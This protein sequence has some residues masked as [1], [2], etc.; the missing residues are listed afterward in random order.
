VNISIRTITLC[1]LI[2]TSYVKTTQGEI[3]D[4]AYRDGVGVGPIKVNWHTALAYQYDNGAK[5]NY[6]IQ[7][8]GS[9][10]TI[11]TWNSF[12]GGNTYK[13]R[14]CP[15]GMS[16]ALRQ[17]AIYYATE[18]IG[19][20][21]WNVGANWTTFLEDPFGATDDSTWVAP[22]SSYQS[23]DGSFRCD[24][25]VE[26]V[27]AQLGLNACNIYQLYND[28]G[29]VGITYGFDFQFCGPEYQFGVY[30]SAVQTPPTSVAMTFPFSTDYQNPTTVSSSSVT[31]GATASDVQSGLSYNQPYD[32]WVSTWTGS[33]W[34]TWSRIGS[35]GPSLSYTVAPGVNYAFYV[36]AFDNDGNGQNSGVY[37]LYTNPSVSAPTVQ[38]GQPTGVT[39]SSATLNGTITSTGGASIINARFEYTSSTFPGTVIYNVPVSGNTFSYYLI[40][41]QP[42]TSY[43]YHCFAENSAGLWNTT[44][45]NVTFTT[46]PPPQYTITASSG[47][48]G[49][50]SP[51]GSLVENAGNNLTLTAYPNSNFAVNQWLVDGYIVQ[52]GGISYTLSN[53]QSSHSVQVTY[54]YILPQYTIMV[55]SGTGGTISPSGSLIEN[56]GNN[57]TL[58][59]YPNS[60]YVV[61]QWLVDGNVMQSEG[62]SYTL[63]NIQTAHNVLVTFTYVPPQYTITASSGIGGAISPSGSLVENAG[64]NQA[65]TAFPNANYVVNQ[66]LVDGNVV[67][68]GDISYTLFNI[69][70]SHS[71]QV[72]FTYVPPDTTPPTVTINNPTNGQVLAT[73]S[74][75]VSGTANDPGNPSSGLASVSI[76][77]GASNE[78][79][80]ANWQF[81][82]N[83]NPGQN[84]LIV[85]ATDQAGNIGEEQ[86]NVTLAPY[87]IAWGDDTFGQTNLPSNL[88]NVVAIAGG[89]YH[90]LALNADGTVVSWG[91]DTY[92]ETNVPEG[93]T[94]A[95]AIAGGAYYSLALNADGTVVSWGDDTYGQTNL[96]SNLTNVVAIAGC[97]QHSLA[98][99]SNGTVVGWGS[100]IYGETDVP[101]D[102]TNVVGIAGGFWHSLALE[103]NGTVT[104]WG[105]NYLGDGNVP[106]GLTNVVSIAAG[107]YH[108]LA[109]RSDGT[110]VAWGAGET[111]NP[112]DG[113]DFGQSIVPPGLTNVVA[114]AAGEFHSLAL[115]SDG[116]VIAWGAGE[117]NN[118]YYGEYD[119]SIVPPGLTNVVTIA[120]GWDHSL[121]LVGNGSLG[122]PLVLLNPTLLNKTFNVSV[123][124]TRG[125]NYIL[126]YKTSLQ[127]VNWILLSPMPGDGT[128]K[129]LSYPTANISKGFFRILR[130]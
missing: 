58:T 28:Y 65:F 59:A 5:V 16:P 70:T 12:L 114:I 105:A 68:S 84:S 85:A 56:A 29:T 60:N 32:Y 9:T 88:T 42:S 10:V 27:Y 61:N 122:S 18:Q 113:W 83:L 20:K 34:T 2:F 13:G 110:V 45:N 99:K 55:S 94:N 73:S 80:L 38:T 7:A 25:L 53:I 11:A 50:I 36:T 74:I 72:T 76:N 15:S 40:G 104:V 101:L 115:K 98:L 124:T 117:T 102:L 79:T 49:A 123:S 66:W 41:L 130:Q 37:Y 127:D 31:L 19:A 90:S 52:F 17:L 26:W 93:L 21:Y 126:E 51:S 1:V 54:M 100:D 103:A 30:P 23:G 8:D 81:A 64:N 128:T 77:T 120:G 6:V 87:V 47:T 62:L 89:G 71:V 116:T 97:G 86:I 46:A 125:R 112:S 69:Q 43:T 63:S 118:P 57:L 3:G 111:Y 95:V 106:T 92:G 24:G 44:E 82:V 35:S 109:L 91:F 33:A 108:N 22:N 48:G 67:Q 4:A 96:P 119:Q 107:Y 14:A 39:S 78:G 75:T 129:T 121:A